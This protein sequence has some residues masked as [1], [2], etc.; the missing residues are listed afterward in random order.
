MFGRSGIRPRLEAGMDIGEQRRTI[1]I[2]PIEEPIPV[3][4]PGPAV[5]PAIEPRRNLE[6]D[7]V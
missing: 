7:R 3:E 4:P 6:P 5:E 2:E 1:W